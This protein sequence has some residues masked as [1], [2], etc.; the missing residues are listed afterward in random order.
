[1]A[2]DLDS[3]ESAGEG[4][5]CGAAENRVAEFIDGE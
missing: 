2:A 4:F 3:A 5:V 1:M